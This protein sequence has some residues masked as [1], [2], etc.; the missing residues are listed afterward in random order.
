VISQDASLRENIIEFR[1]I[2]II[3]SPN[4]D[5]SKVPIQPVFA[6][7]IAAEVECFRNSPPDSPI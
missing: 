4:L 5:A 2:G 6:S 1:P 3:H 7:E